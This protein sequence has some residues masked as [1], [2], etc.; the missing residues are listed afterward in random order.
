MEK[1]ETE[2][3]IIILVSSGSDSR[4]HSGAHSL[5]VYTQ[6]LIG[7]QVKGMDFFQV[8]LKR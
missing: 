5:G 2:S 4:D 7:S 8:E 1:Y 3:N 6:S